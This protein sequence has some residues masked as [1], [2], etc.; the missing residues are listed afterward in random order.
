M[1]W[2]KT[3][4]FL[5][6]FFPERL[7]A[8]KEE[9]W[10]M[11]IHVKFKPCLFRSRFLNISIKDHVGIYYHI[12]CWSMCYIFITRKAWKTNHTLWIMPCFCRQT[13]K[14]LSQTFPS[15]GSRRWERLLH[16]TPPSC[17]A[18]AVGWSHFKGVRQTAEK[19]NKCLHYFSYFWPIAELQDR[20]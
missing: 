4:P 7:S 10:E 13:C 14:V 15:V 1:S 5:F 18:S 19:R 17:S 6:F 16:H 20:F 8:L 2:H 12:L 9:K 11:Y 3:S